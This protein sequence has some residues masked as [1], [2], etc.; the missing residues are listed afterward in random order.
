[1]LTRVLH[2]DPR[3][4][5]LDSTVRSTILKPVALGALVAMLCIGLANCSGGPAAAGFGRGGHPDLVLEH[6]SV[7][8]SRPAAGASFTFSATVRSIGGADTAGATLRVY[9]SDDATIT[10]EDEEA[11]ATTAEP[12]TS[13]SVASV[14]LRAPADAGTY[15]YGV[16]VTVVDGESDTTNNCSAAVRVTV[17]D[18]SPPTR[19]P[20]APTQQPPAPTQQPPAP[21]QQPPGPDL[22]VEYVTVSEEGA[23]AGQILLVAAKVRNV[24]DKGAA[25]TSARLYLSADSTITPAD[26]AVHSERLSGL[27]PAQYKFV[28]D[29]VVAPSS[30]GTYYY[31]AC[32]T[33]VD[34][35]SD[36]T[37]N[38]SATSARVTVRKPPAPDLVITS[39]SFGPRHPAAG[40]VFEIAAILRNDGGLSHGTVIRFSVSDDATF[41]PS[42]TEVHSHWWGPFHSHGTSYPS[43]ILDVPATLGTYHFRMC[44]DAVRGESNTTNNCS[45]PVKVVVSHAKPNLRIGSWGVG[46]WN[47]PSF[48][49]NAYVVNLGGASGATTLRF[50]QSTDRTF[51]ASDTEIHTVAVG[52]L[53]KTE[54]RIAPTFDS[55]HVDV[56]PPATGTH[57]Y[58]AC[59]DAVANESDTSDNCSKVIHTI[60]R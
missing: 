27:A 42:D 23:V 30:P 32:V 21:T 51:T 44:A 18:A 25:E 54:S 52:P 36:T 28:W 47:G 43:A 17:L 37:N 15:Y 56:T 50:Y 4:V 3:S 39:P 22:E 38:C 59:V 10:P 5:T 40:G 13:E 19:Q 16:C 58:F 7:T 11:A 35:E 55:G 14:T 29:H 53:T 45:V 20:P 60:R 34:G 12:A 49:I 33:A 26:G 48:P 1:M 41:K 9:R 31:G 24:G 6:P 8:N 46:N 2:G 57:H